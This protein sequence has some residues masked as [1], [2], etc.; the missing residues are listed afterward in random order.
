MA[1]DSTIGYD[2]TLP[3]TNVAQLKEKESKKDSKLPSGFATKMMRLDGAHQNGN[4]A[5]PFWTAAII[6]A[7]VVGMDKYTMNVA[8]I[9]YIG[10]RLLYN[11][12]YIYHNTLLK[13]WARTIVFFAGVSI[14]LYLL[15]N[16][17]GLAA[18]EG[19]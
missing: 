7:H 9:A 4:E 2:N 13:G 1:I 11:Q 3:R 14:P 19:P 10:L 15:I 12:I 16:S 5:F 6:T 18:S 17:A 8:S